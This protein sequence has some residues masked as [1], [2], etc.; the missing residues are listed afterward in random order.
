MDLQNYPYTNVGGLSCHFYAAL[1]A[2]L[3]VIWLANWAG[4]KRLAKRENAVMI[5][6]EDAKLSS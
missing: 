6:L 4:G 2:L 5:G 3:I 1:S